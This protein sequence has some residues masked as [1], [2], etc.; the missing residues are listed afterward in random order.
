MPWM[1]SRW[2][3][4]SPPECILRRGMWLNSRSAHLLLWVVAIAVLAVRASDTH[5]HLCFD[6]QEPPT[7]LHFADASVHDDEH[8][9]EGN[10]DDQDFD[11]FIGVLLK[12]S[13]SDSDV[14]LPLGVAALVLL[15][16]PVTD[17]LP[18]TSDTLPSAVDPPFYLRP[19][20]RGP[21]A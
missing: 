5:L 21:P 6:G 19:P 7:T 18:P 10:H 11:P 17:T 12:N 14:A 4:D 13:G 8:H 20:L 3:R 15:L 2:W 9:D 16:P 1:S